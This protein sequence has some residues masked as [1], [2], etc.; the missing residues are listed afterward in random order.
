MIGM[1]SDEG[2]EWEFEVP[3][4]PEGS[5]EDWMNKVDD[6]MKSSLTLM[7]KKSVFN[8]AKTDRIEWI[9]DQ[10]GMIA[11]LGTQI[12][13]TFAVEDVFVQVGRGNK[14]AMK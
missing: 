8:Y 7:A 6:E 14:H 4:K 2:E 3:V 10:I 9:C 1:T 5:V 11:L 13:W 12:W